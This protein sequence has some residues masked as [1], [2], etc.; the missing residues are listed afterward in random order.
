MITK[1]KTDVANLRK[2]GPFGSAVTEYEKTKMCYSLSF[3]VIGRLTFCSAFRRFMTIN[4][5]NGL[6]VLLAAI[7]D[8]ACLQH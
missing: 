1:K 7:N 4:N 6:T 3:D 8:L 2:M 5:T